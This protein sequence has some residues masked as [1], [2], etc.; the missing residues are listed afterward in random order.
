MCVSVCGHCNQAGPHVRLRLVSVNEQNKR[1]SSTA[2]CQV[3]LGPCAV[4]GG[5]DE[6]VDA[7][8][9]V[10]EKVARRV[11]TICAGRAVVVGKAAVKPFGRIAAPGPLIDFF[12]AVKGSLVHAAVIGC[13][14]SVTFVYKTCCDIKP[15]V[16]GWYSN[17]AGIAAVVG[18]DA[19]DGIC[20]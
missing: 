4:K 2:E 1:D 6:L 11:R 14:G 19:E 15:P 17:V 5:V 9:Y 12:C 3:G 13:F 18:V 10:R 7:L 16:H 20:Q 8:G